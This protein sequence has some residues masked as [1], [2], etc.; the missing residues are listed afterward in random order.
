VETLTSLL[1]RLHNQRE[2]QIS[3]HQTLINLLSQLKLLQEVAGT[4]LRNQQGLRIAVGINLHLQ[5]VHLA[6]QVVLVEVLL[7]EALARQVAVGEDIVR[8]QI[9]E[10]KKVLDENF[11]N[12]HICLGNSFRNCCPIL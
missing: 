3:R 1:N 4:N 2:R 11:I 10:G 12:N 8:H 5:E 9:K 6:S 7:R